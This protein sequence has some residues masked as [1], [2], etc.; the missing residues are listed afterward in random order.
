MQISLYSWNLFYLSVALMLIPHSMDT[1][2]RIYSRERH[3]LSWYRLYNLLTRGRG[4]WYRS[5]KGSEMYIEL[6]CH[7]VIISGKWINR[8]VGIAQ[9]PGVE[10]CFNDLFW[11][12][13]FAFGSNMLKYSW[14]DVTQENNLIWELDDGT[15]PYSNFKSYCGLVTVVH[16]Q[17]IYDLA[18]AHMCGCLAECS[19]TPP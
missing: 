13:M 3:V 2:P 9:S 7:D 1:I 4:I 19:E 12:V 11:C 17:P 15:E 8:L 18:R 10:R 16:N 6:A 14:Y 5:R